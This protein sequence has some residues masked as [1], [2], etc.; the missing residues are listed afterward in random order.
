METPNPNPEA[1]AS[2]EHRCIALLPVRLRDDLSPRRKT[3]VRNVRDNNAARVAG[4]GRICYFLSL[5]SP[6]RGYPILPRTLRMGAIPRYRPCMHLP[7]PGR[8]RVL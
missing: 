3:A 2:G 5:P 8:A 1:Q 4:A 6:I 7:N